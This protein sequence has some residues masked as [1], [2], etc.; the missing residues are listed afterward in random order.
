M[1]HARMFLLAVCG[2]MFGS[3]PELSR[4]RIWS[5][6][7]PTHQK[8]PC[9]MTCLLTRVRSPG[10]V[11][12]GLYCARTGA[13]KCLDCKI[14]DCRVSGVVVGHGGVV[15]FRGGELSKCGGYGGVALGGCKLTVLPGAPRVRAVIGSEEQEPPTSVRITENRLSGLGA[16]EGGLVEVRGATVSS[17]GECGISGQVGSS[18][19]V[20]ECS[21]SSNATGVALQVLFVRVCVCICVCVC[22][23]VCSR[24]FRLSQHLKWV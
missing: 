22:V 4:S 12:L 14:V 6:I 19:I 10:Q 23:V 7:H 24:N 9:K 11:G 17:N 1:E 15:E 20:V 18:I 21:V 8:F 16:R 2:R 3:G 13:V 5:K